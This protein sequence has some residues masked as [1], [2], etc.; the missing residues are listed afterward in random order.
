MRQATILADGLGFVEGPRWH[1]GRLWLSD[2]TAG[3]VLALGPEGEVEPVVAVPGEPSGL[4]WLP[5]GRLLVVS[6]EHRRLMRLDPDGL[7][8]HADL[9]G[10]ATFHCNDMVVDAQGRAWVGNWGFDLGAYLDGRGL[11]AVSALP[12]LPTAALARV[13]PDGTVHVAATG[14]RFPNGTVIT[15]DGSTLVVAETF[16]ERL[17]AFAITADGTLANRRVWAELPGVVPDGIA[18]DAARA[19]WVANPTAPE[20]LRVAPG[21]AVLERVA[22]SQPCYACALGGPDRAT[23]YLLTNPPFDASAIGGDGGRIETVA[24]AV[25][26]VG[27]P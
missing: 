15:P 11:L 5:D 18:L 2:S 21:G 1:E 4:G 19:I 3:A 6:W 13:D 23:L 17:T 16:G 14:L 9:R 7:V 24:V 22:T 20:C 8:E 27:W 10:V 25:P 26:G 12:D